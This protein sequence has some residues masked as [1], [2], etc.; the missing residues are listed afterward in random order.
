MN[1][2]RRT[3]QPPVRSEWQL[4]ERDVLQLPSGHYRRWPLDA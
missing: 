1:E 4:V 2:R 3:E